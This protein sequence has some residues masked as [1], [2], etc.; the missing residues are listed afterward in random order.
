VLIVAAALSAYRAS[1]SGVFVLDDGPAIVHNPN[2]R[3][4]WPLSRAMSAP[5]EVTVAARPIVSLTLALNYA[6]APDDARDVLDVT[7]DSPPDRQERYARNLWGYHLANLAIHILAGLTLFGIVRRTLHAMA[8]RVAGAHPTAIAAI[9]ALVWV[10]HPIQTDSVTYIVQRAESLMGLFYLLTVYCAIRAA[11]AT[12]PRAW[13]AGSIAA[14]ALGMGSKEAM[15]SAP[16]MVWV[17]DRIAL[18]PGAER[19]A[20]RAGRLVLYTGLAATWLLL[21]WLMATQPR[22]HSVG[23]SF[24][25]WPWWRYLVTQ[26]GVVVH[27]LRLAVIPAPLVLDYGWPAARS[28]LDVA[29]QAALLSALVAVTGLAIWRRRPEGLLGAWFFLTLAPTSS[30]VP[31]V[32]E[33]AAEHRMYLPLAAIVVAAVVGVDTLLRR[34]TPRRAAAIGWAMSCAVVAAGIIAT[35]RR[36]HDYE[37]DERMWLDTMQKRPANARAQNN[38]AVDLIARGAPAEAVEPLETA[39][40]LDGQFAD[41]HAN[42]GVALCKLGRAD[43]GI[44]HLER[45]LALDAGNTEAMRNLGEAYAAQGRRSGAVKYFTAA[46]DARADDTFLLNRLGWLLATSPEDEIRNGAK[47]VELAERAVRV[48]SRLDV[49][50]LDTLGAAYAEVDR[51]DEAVVIAREAVALAGRLD[52]RGMMPELESRLALYAARQKFRE[53]KR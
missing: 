36:N 30:V 9:V 16:L 35:D 7:P 51:F 39:V 6:M 42:L 8:G 32:T 10:V 24:A 19:G 11:L 2:I 15:V 44:A 48:T 33:V 52:D 4:L 20:S 46:L 47:A 25:G 45:A 27:Y 28:V 43:E 40:R 53:G 49:T 17:W 26:A 23:F 29:P 13:I 14:C 38:Y 1:F 12:N 18:E 31:I 21:A 22:S 3:S 50:S 5:P 37:S 41:A 34:V